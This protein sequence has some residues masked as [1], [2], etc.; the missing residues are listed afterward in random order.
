MPTGDEV[1]MQTSL[2][3][4]QHTRISKL[5]IGSATLGVRYGMIIAL[6]QP[7]YAQ[8]YTKATRRPKADQF[9]EE[10]VKEFMAAVPLM[11]GGNG[12]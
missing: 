4:A 2:Y 3:W 8:A 12:A 1:L 10:A 7:D 11:A 6:R 9:E 5:D